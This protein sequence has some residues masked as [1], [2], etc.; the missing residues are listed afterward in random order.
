[1]EKV[2]PYVCPYLHQGCDRCKTHSEKWCPAMQSRDSILKENSEI[3][4][5]NGALKAF[6]RNIKSSMEMVE[7]FRIKE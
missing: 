1:M 5:V 2:N 7:L 6:A 4:Q 3:R